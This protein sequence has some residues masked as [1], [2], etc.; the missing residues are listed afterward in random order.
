[1]FDPNPNSL[2]NPS[3]QK[4]HLFKILDPKGSTMNEITRGIVL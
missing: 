2:V 3:L 4:E 1:M